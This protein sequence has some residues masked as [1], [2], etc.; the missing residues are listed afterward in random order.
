[1]P[2][3]ET[4]AMAYISGK[5]VEPTK[6]EVSLFAAWV[7]TRF[8]CIGHRV[9]FICEDVSPALCGSH[10]RACGRLLI[11][12]ANN[13]DNLWGEAV[14]A[15][16]RAVHD[17]DHFNTGARFD[18]DGEVS[19]YCAAAETAPREI[20]WIL[21]SE[22]VLQAAACIYTGRFNEQKLVHV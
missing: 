5:P 1:M 3:L 17:F 9:D 14:N 7:D 2:T 10:Y 18:L 12:T 13:T 4:L 6:F 20:L 15:R 16:F 22:I 21:Y 11:S 8:A 19:A